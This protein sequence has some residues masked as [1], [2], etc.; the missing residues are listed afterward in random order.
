MKEDKL[1]QKALKKLLSY[2]PKTGEFVWMDDRNHMAMAGDKAGSL[3]VNGY[4]CIFVFNKSYRAHR[5][6]WLY[7]TG[8]WPKEQI[9][10]INHIRDDN[11]WENLREVNSSENQ[12]NRTIN[13]NNT[14]GITGVYLNK[15]NNTWRGMICVDCKIITLGSYIDKFEAICARKSAEIKYK[16]HDNHGANMRE[17]FR[18]G[19][20]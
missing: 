5:L 3:N 18:N 19:R 12:R 16:Y 17:G 11:R 10:H 7:M 6:A 14:S 20:H 2:N 8:K 9:D 1:N 15:F 13:R 4:V